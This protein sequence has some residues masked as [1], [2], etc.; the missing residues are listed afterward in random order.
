M[1]TAT[2]I[3][4]FASGSGSNAE[5]LAR[6]FKDHPTIS[7]S[8][9]LSDKASAYVLERARNLDVPHAVFT[10]AEFTQETVSNPV[11]AFLAEEGIDLVVLAGFLGKI[12]QVLI[13]QFPARI[14]NIHP[15]LLPKYGGKGMYGSHVHKAVIA[16]GESESGITIHLVNEI[17]DDGRV[18]Y[19]ASCS[20]SPG[21]TPDDLAKKIHALEHQHFPKVVAQ[22]IDEEAKP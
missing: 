7:V 6:F 16:A 20:V 17:Y 10:R 21:D 1:S 8:L 3:A 18:L 12:P 22:Y 15:S 5:N 14:I 13:R 2:K 4:I 19:Q 9:I 11:A